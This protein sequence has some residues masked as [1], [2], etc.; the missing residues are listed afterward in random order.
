MWRMAGTLRSSA[1][2]A[3]RTGFW[4]LLSIKT[5]SILLSREEFDQAIWG[6]WFK[7]KGEVRTIPQSDPSNDSDGCI[8]VSIWRDAQHAAPANRMPH[9]ELADAPLSSVVCR[10]R[11][12]RISSGYGVQFF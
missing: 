6:D 5:D 12:G 7:L 9:G 8:G 4:T 3:A 11:F 1:N 10:R 2:S